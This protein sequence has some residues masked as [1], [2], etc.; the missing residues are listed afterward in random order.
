M[1]MLLG[2]KGL[3]VLYKSRNMKKKTSPNYCHHCTNL[4]PRSIETTY[5]KVN[6]AE[7]WW[8]QLSSYI[9]ILVS[10]PLEKI[11]LSN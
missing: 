11:E 2:P 6:T 8:S 1:G 3:S 4:N 10:M 9:D 5:G 7:C